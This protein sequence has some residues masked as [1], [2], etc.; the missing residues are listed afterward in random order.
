MSKKNSQKTEPSEEQSKRSE[1]NIVEPS[2]RFDD[3]D[4]QHAFEALF[5]SGEM[6][7]ITSIGYARVPG[8]NTFCS[9]VMKSKG[10]EV[11]KIEMGEPNL[12]PIAEDE[13]KMNF[14]SQ[15]MDTT[16]A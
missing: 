1:K 16:D 11:L 8:K 12:R 7:T 14:V 13:A 4:K 2:I 10:T 5:E 6:P 9:F 15:L 3:E